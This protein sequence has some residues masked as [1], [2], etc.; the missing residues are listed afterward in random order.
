MP[1]GV[2]VIPFVELVLNAI[3]V[4]ALAGIE[5]NSNANASTDRTT[6]GLLMISASLNLRAQP[7]LE[8]HPE[9]SR[10]DESLFLVIGNALYQTTFSPLKAPEGWR[11]VPATLL[12]QTSYSIPLLQRQWDLGTIFNL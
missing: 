6:H 11:R 10:A 4:C 2:N 9:T 3:P 7:S 1:V 5:P 8:K 12:S